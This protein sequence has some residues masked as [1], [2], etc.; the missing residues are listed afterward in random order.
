M[1]V[2]ATARFYSDPTPGF[3]FTGIVMFILICW[4]VG[5]AIHNFGPAA[6]RRT[7]AAGLKQQ[8]TTIQLP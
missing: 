4:V 3:I 6:K 7:A 8:D 5:I 1:T 2:L